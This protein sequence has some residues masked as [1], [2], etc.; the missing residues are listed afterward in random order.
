MTRKWYAVKQKKKQPTN[1]LDIN[2]V[3]TIACRQI[4]KNV[5]EE[6]NAIK[7]TNEPNYDIK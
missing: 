5:I 4:L 2:C 6:K 1:Q 3:H 7:F